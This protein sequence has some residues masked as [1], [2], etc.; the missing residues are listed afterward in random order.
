VQ[1]CCNEDV[2]EL[3]TFFRNF[4]VKYIPLLGKGCLYIPGSEAE[5]EVFAH[6]VLLNHIFVFL[7]CFVLCP[8]QFSLKKRSS[9]CGT[10]YSL[11]LH[12]YMLLILFNFS[13]PVLQ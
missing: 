8:K 9:D 13:Y 12:T 3:V 1:T 2:T 11:V 7:N 6:E 4:V 5:Y 10:L